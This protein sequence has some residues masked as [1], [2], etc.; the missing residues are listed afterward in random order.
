MKFLN[1]IVNEMS[2]S[3]TQLFTNISA[4]FAAVMTY[5]FGNDP[6]LALKIL[7]IMIGADYVTGILASLA[8][9]KGVNSKVGFKGILKKVSMVLVV[10]IS[11][12]IDLLLAA[13]GL[14]MM[15][16]IYFF[17]SNELIS[18]AE[19]VGRIGVPLPPV[20]KKA[21]T[22]LQEKSESEPEFEENKNKK[23][24]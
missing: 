13:N 6:P 15:G 24:K 23:S 4:G 14:I 3:S 1:N 19:N 11:H 20:I 5:S 9:K 8:E 12:K 7:L 16:S 21:I 22:V 2:Y 10:F 18:F 17:I